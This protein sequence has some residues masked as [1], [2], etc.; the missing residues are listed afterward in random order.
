ME[1]DIWLLGVVVFEE[2][3]GSGLAGEVGDDW[4]IHFGVRDSFLL[5]FC[6]FPF[7]E[8]DIL[9]KLFLFHRGVHITLLISGV[10]LEF[11]GVLRILEVGLPC[12]SSCTPC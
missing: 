12:F 9:C 2:V 10:F 3:L 11:G 4:L 8:D 7:D 1:A 6:F 5:C